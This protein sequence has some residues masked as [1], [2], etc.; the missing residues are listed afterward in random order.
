[1]LL[2]P[3][4]YPDFTQELV[5]NKPISMPCGPANLGFTEPHGCRRA[6]GRR[7]DDRSNCMSWKEP[8]PS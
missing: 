5:A 6:S 8:L 7:Q 2:T 1:V 4:L 3:S